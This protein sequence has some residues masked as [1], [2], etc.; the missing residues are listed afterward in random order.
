MAA[1][2][3]EQG[4]HR[5]L[6]VGCGE[7]GSRHLQAVASLP[8]VKEIEVV[9]PRPDALRLGWERLADLPGPRPAIEVRWVSSVEEASKEGGLCI[10]ATQAQGRCQLLRH[11]AETLGYTS[12]LLEKIVAPSV[13]EMVDSVEFTSSRGLSAWVNLQTR[14]APFFQQAKG[15]LDPSEPIAFNV[16]GGMQ[17]LAT[18]G[19][20]GA[21][22]FAFFDDCRSIE[23][24]GSQVDPVLHP[25]K[26]GSHLYDLRGTLHGFTPKGSSLTISHIDS[27]S[28]WGH[29]SIASSR[30]R[31]F[32]DYL[33]HWAMEGGPE[34]GWAWRQ[35]PFEG[36]MLVS[37]TTKEFTTDILT[38]GRCALPTLE[39]SLVS[40]RFILE[41]LR[42]HFCRLLGRS[43][44]QLPV[45]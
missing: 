3:P 6:I 14:A 29:V 1:S 30:Y 35:V 24:S 9:D 41:E 18:H 21:D 8:L 44:D 16:V 22:L 28:A 42:P 17:F 38:S 27:G 26:R 2:P 13:P 43:L 15:R 20:H 31:C 37:Q 10:I 23:G 45:T 25:S 7:L 19:I 4:C 40:H 5:V 34:S 12:F 39:E 36:N 33:Q 11:I 32:V